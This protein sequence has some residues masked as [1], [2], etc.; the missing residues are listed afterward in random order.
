MRTIRLDD[1]PDG[2]PGYDIKRNRADV[3]A[4]LAIFEEFHVPY[5]LG[6]TPLLLE[7]SDIEFLNE[8]VKTGK[9]VMHG[10]SHLLDFKPWEKIVETWPKGG[11]FV[12]MSY[13]A[14]RAQHGHCHTILAGV[15]RY[16]RSIFIPPFNCMTQEAF[17]ALSDCGVRE[18][19]TCD[20]EWDAYGYVQMNHYG[21]VPI[22]SKFQV[23]YDYAHKVIDH[24]D[25]PSQIT[26]HWIFD[27]GHPDWL[28][29]YRRLCERLTTQKGAVP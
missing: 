3:A 21:I 19:H 16:D 1:F 7:S 29:H 12:G 8:N 2:N 11:E 13:E 27:R 24:L 20:K 4:A 17:R 26:L 25:D 9:A 6:V 23:T 15:H 28:G 5:I 10:F 22:V 14:I 18:V